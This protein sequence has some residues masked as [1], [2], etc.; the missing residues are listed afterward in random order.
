VRLLATA[1]GLLRAEKFIGQ[2]VVARGWYRRM[3]GPV[4]ELRDVKAADGRIAR[5]WRWRMR[6][7]GS[8]LLALA[9]VIVVLASLAS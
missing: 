7:V 3:P 5:S 1:F 9:G 6:F 2:E 4:V 8:V